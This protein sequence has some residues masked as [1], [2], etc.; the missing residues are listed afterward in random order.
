MPAR[1][2]EHVDNAPRNTILLHRDSMQERNI[3]NNFAQQSTSEGQKS[4][5]THL[6]TQ[7]PSHATKILL[8]TARV[9]ISSNKNRKVQIR[10]LLDQGSTWS[11]VSSRLAATLGARRIQT[12]ASMTGLGGAP[13]GTSS[14]AIDIKLFD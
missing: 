12:A 7:N 10:A 4:V 14:T 1:A 13:A 3:S 5:Q 9:W 2:R 8:A 6:S 11:F